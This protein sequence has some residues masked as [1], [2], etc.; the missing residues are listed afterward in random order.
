V[1]GNCE[2]ASPVVRAWWTSDKPRERDMASALC[3]GCPATTACQV[4]ADKFTPTAGV[5]AGVDYDSRTAAA[6]GAY[7]KAVDQSTTRTCAACGGTY[8]KPRWQT[9]TE[10]AART[11]CSRACANKGTA[12]RKG[13][14]A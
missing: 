8:G 7:E 5:W 2:V 1:S 14:A 3:T 12:K 4:L 10:W 6:R 11:F 13:K 9:K